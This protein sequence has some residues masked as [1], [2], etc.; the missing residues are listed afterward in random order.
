MR[1]FKEGTKNATGST[2]IELFFVLSLLISI[3]RIFFKKHIEV[4]EDEMAGW[5]HGPNGHEFERTPRDSEG[6]GSLV[7]YSPWGRKESDMT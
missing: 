7:G 1:I 4:T 2:F 5:L 3:S 6:Q